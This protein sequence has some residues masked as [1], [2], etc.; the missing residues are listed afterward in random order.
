MSSNSDAPH[1]SVERTDVL[2]L[3]SEVV[4]DASESGNMPKRIRGSKILTDIEQNAV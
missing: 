3:Q 4:C 1:Y 2:E